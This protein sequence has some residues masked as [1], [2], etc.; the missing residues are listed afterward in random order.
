MSSFN[1]KVNSVRV[2]EDELVVGL[3][4]GRMLSVPLA[5]YPTLLHANKR[6]RAKWQTC[7]AGTGIHWLLIDYH[8]S[9]QGLLE[10]RPEH[11]TNAAPQPIRA[12]A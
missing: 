9:A 8:L 4:D 10:G 7:A 6:Q 5:W 2:T 12:T 3:T 1:A 11:A